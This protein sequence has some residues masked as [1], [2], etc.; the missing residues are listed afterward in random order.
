MMG[1]PPKT[2]LPWRCRLFGHRY[3]PGGY[4]LEPDGNRI[5]LQ[6][7]RRCHNLQEFTAN[8]PRVE[9]HIDKSTTR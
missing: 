9:L 3:A 8:S 7:C 5:P 4:A 2:T 6:V 1:K